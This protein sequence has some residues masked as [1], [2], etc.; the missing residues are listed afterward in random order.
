VPSF[1]EDWE[2]S[3]ASRRRSKSRIVRSPNSLPGWRANTAAGQYVDQALQP[4]AFDIPSTVRS[5]NGQRRD[6]ERVALVTG[7]PLAARMACCVG[8]K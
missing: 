4:R 6:A 5:I 1:G 7:V 8:A 2:W 3:A